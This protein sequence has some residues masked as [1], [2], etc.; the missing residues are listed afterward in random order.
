MTLKSKNLLVGAHVSIAGGVYNAIVNGEKIGATA[1]QMFSKNQ[2]RWISKPL[3]DEDA[4]KFRNDW[5]NSTIQEIVIHDSYLINLGSPDPV[6]LQKSRDAFL[7]EVERAEKLGV[8]YLIFHPGSHLETGEDV[9]LKTIAES[10]NG[11][12][13]ARPGYDVKLLLET[14]AGQ[15]TNLGYTF[16]QL[17]QIMELVE[18]KQ[19]QGVCLDTAHVFAAG[20]DIRTK[21]TYEAMFTEFDS[22]I[23]LE[24]LLAIHVN[25]SKKEL[26][27]RVDRHENI[28]EGLLGREPFRFLMNDSR[29]TDVPKLLETPGKEE[30]FRR[31]LFLL[32]S[33][34][35]TN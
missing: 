17:A 25:D 11:V 29:F 5:Q 27:S 30:D 22:I 2:T 23:G 32:K 31:N 26:G 8:R 16:E 6:L 20:Y 7:D 15:G 28:G 34:V 18:D 10:M 33:L 19:R 9:G 35:E 14:T 21:E 1:I 4:A 24:S 12:I 13:D 3:S